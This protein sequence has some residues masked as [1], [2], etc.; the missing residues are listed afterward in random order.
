MIEK[1]LRIM[2]IYIPKINIHSQSWKD[3]I[4]Q[5]IKSDKQKNIYTYSYS[6]NNRRVVYKD[7]I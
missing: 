3:N 6:E 2:D 5:Y 7:I 4:S 1:A